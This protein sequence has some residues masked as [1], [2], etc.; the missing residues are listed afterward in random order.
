[1]WWVRVVRAG[2]QG[3]STVAHYVRFV[4]YGP[5]IP[6]SYSSMDHAY[7]V[8]QDWANLI[9]SHVENKDLIIFYFCPKLGALFFFPSSL[10]FNL[11]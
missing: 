10:S 5:D 9:R 11:F 1:M 3:P 2:A 6:G 8:I 7:H 4:A